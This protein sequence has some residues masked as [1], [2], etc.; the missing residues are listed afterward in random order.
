M[1]DFN[2]QKEA[3]VRYNEEKKIDSFT[4]RLNEDERKT[5]EAAKKQI[6]QTKDSTAIKQLAWF[7]AKVIQEEKVGYLLATLFKNKRNNSRLGIIDF[8]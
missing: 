8:D 5:L 3:F 7:G 4:I 2:I 6:E 1:D